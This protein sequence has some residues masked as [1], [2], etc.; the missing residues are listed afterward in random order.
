[1]T[2]SNFTRPSDAILSIAIPTSKDEFDEHRRT[3]R[4]RDFVR[5]CCPLW[6]K[7]LNDVIEPFQ[8]VIPQIRRWGVEVIPK[9]T[10]SDWE[11]A[12]GS[13]RRVVTL[14]AHFTGES[15][16]FYDGL[17]PIADVIRKVPSDFDGIVDL[18]MC[19]PEQLVKSLK[20]ER[21]RCL[22]RFSNKPL[23]PSLWFY[24]YLVLYKV[25]VSENIGYLDA[26]EKT[27]NQFNEHEARRPSG[28]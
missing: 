27:I 22:V 16:E 26:L 8:E 17:V 5:S 18:C 20:A 14:F 2:Q 1:M 28:R 13:R 15:V 3:P 25:L 4:N 11:A 7:Y 24:F 10:L 21:P 23:T 6:G 9:V 19:L 12:F